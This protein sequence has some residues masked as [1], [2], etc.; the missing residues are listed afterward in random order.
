MFGTKTAVAHWGLSREARAVVGGLGLALPLVVAAVVV[1]QVMSIAQ[2]RVV[3]VFLINVIAVV[4]IG[5]FTGNSGILS[6]G[7]VSFMALGA[8]L[9]GLLTI[10]VAQKA[11][12][13]PNLPTFLGETEMGMFP[14]MLL[15]MALVAV[16]VGAP[17]GTGQGLATR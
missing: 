10:P 17:G 12:L 11:M 15:A 2:E 8:Y 3:T 16:V 9:S 13:L 4:S 7:R 5:V 6:F 1:S 14:A